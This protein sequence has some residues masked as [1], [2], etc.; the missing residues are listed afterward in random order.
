MDYALLIDL[1]KSKKERKKVLT[2]NN[3]ISADTD[4][5]ILLHDRYSYDFFPFEGGE[6]ASIQCLGISRAFY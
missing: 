6:N 5:K 3:S 1:E 4:L 2:K